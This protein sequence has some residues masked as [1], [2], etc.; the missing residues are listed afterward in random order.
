[1]GLLPVAVAV[2]GLQYALF[3]NAWALLGID[4]HPLEPTGPPPARSIGAV[5]SLTGAIS[6][7]FGAFW[8][9]IGAPLGREGNVVP[10][11]LTFSVVMAIYGF[12][13]LGVSIVQMAGWDLR[14]VGNA[15]LI[16]L[17]MTII[18]MIVI[19]AW[20]LTLH[21]IL[22]EVVLLSYLLVLLGFWGVTHGK[23][24]PKVEGVLLL[25]A[26][27]LSFYLMLW[28]SGILPA[29]GT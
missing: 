10:M 5:G 8:L 12:L 2:V 1:M 24:A 20:G 6:L 27:I 13:W 9:V 16:A 23:L 11:Q 21:L 3:C 17:I 19:G 4:A 28:A 29:P 26:M 22:V 7:L 18:A 14:P 15:A 25:I